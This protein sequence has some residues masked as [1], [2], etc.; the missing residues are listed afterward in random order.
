MFDEVHSAV[1]T[2]KTVVRDLEPGVLDGPGAL[3]LVELFA[4]AEHVA[5]AG[6]AIAARR[7]DA[8]GAHRE[9]GHRSAGEL[10]ARVSGVTVGA[11]ESTLR[12]AERLEELPAT[13][14][15]FRAGELSEVQAREISYAASQDPSAEGALLGTARRQ[16]VKGLKQRCARV[17]AASVDDDEAWARRLHDQRAV[18]VWHEHGALR[19]DVTLAP[20]RAANVHAAL[21][22]ETDRIFRDAR[23]AGQREPRVAYMAD[24]L[25]NLVTNGP[26]K[27]IDA[28][29]N[30]DTTALERG[31]VIAGETCELEGLGPIPV[32]SARQLL[33]D[34]RVTLLVHDDDRISHVSS[35][36][37]T[38][39]AKLR[40]WLEATYPECGRQGCNNT[41][42]LIIDHIERY[43]DGGILDEHNAWRL[44][45]T[46]NDLK[47]HR[48]WKV[49]GTPGRWDLVPP[50]HADPDH[51]DPP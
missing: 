22:A 40:R 49:I 45:P 36:T 2:L 18:Y 17:V 23:A 50:D 28:R 32:T 1:A 12:T 6:K 43:T 33:R 20:D 24:A 16:P 8:T 51:P 10:L 37:R 14:A 13:D 27:P 5:A 38:V 39:P 3:R 42:N 47:T 29:L 7:V 46:C 15:A 44:C 4:E 9:R 41:R 19:A 48:G 31:H 34:A 35:V 25:A 21:E 26:S 11:A 30:A